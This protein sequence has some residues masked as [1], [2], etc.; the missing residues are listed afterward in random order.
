MPFYEHVILRRP[1]VSRKQV[2]QIIE[3]IGA[4]L[5]AGGGATVKHEYWGL[6]QTAYPIKKQSKAHYALLYIDSPAPAVQE[7]ERRLRF[8]GDVLR[9]LT[10]KVDALEEGPSAVMQSK[11]R[12][13]N[14]RRRDSESD[15]PTAEA[16]REETRS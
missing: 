16:P 2:D 11:N 13:E 14:R 15:L 12:E 6:R 4:V 1:E 7:A 10:V 5:A 9:F 3:D 8:N